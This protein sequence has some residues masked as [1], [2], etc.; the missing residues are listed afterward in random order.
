MVAPY[1]IKFVKQKIA[2]LLRKINKSAATRA[3]LFDSNMH[4]IVCRLAFRSRPHWGS[5]HRSPKP[6]AIFRGPTSK[7][8]QGERRE[9]EG[10]GKERRQFSFTLGRKKTKV[11]A[12]GR[13][14]GHPVVGG[15]WWITTRVTGVGDGTSITDPDVVVVVLVKV[16]ELGELVV[17][18]VPDVVEVDVPD[19]VLVV[20]PDV[21]VLVE[22]L[23]VVVVV[24]AVVVVVDVRGSGTCVTHVSSDSITAASWSK[25][26]SA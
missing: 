16:V 1:D 23:E 24:A 22:P 26:S 8:R 5:L 20:V 17:V 13:G 15:N 3:A 4:Q 11:G 12:Y 10:M 7:G 2:F 19:V 9:G 25:S 6:L 14:S 18:P 21:V